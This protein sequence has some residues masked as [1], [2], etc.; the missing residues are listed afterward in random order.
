[1]REIWE[2]SKATFAEWEFKQVSL[3]ASSLAY[4]TVFSLAPLLI[5]VIAIV[6]AVFGEA[7]VKHEI[8]LQVQNFVGSKAARVIETAISNTKQ[9]D[10]NQGFFGLLLN[11]ALLIYGSSKV[12]VHL[13]RSLNQIWEVKPEPERNFCYFIRKRFLSLAMVLAIAFLLLVSFTINAI[14]ASTFNFLRGTV[15]GLGYLWQ[16][17]N[18]LISFGAIAL[19]FTLIYKILPDA[20]VAWQDALIGAMLTALLFA[21]GQSLF[22]L[23]LGQ[24]DLGSAYGVAG[25]LVIIITWAYYSAHIL[26]IGAEFTQ[27]YAR[28]RGSPIIPEEYAVRIPKVEDKRLNSPPNKS[29]SR[30]KQ[31]NASGLLA[32]LREHSIRIVQRLIRKWQ[33]RR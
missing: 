14:L 3:L 11:L 4:Y 2:L 18:F 31:K 13:Q 26:L 17:F 19:L 24:T 23:F 22:A 30:R 29:A 25:S 10:I 7:A 5:I 32:N 6:G 33:R 9:P 1:M 20:R 16:T 21:I 28:K 12:F 8:V 27:V 15:P